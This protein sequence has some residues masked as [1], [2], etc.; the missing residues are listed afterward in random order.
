MLGTVAFNFIMSWT[1]YAQRTDRRRKLAMAAGVAGN[2]A[3]LGYF[4][5]AMFVVSSIETLL[6]TSFGMAAIILPIGISFYIFTQIAFLVD[7]WRER[8]TPFWRDRSRPYG[9]LD[10]LLFVTIFPHLIAGPI[11]H[12]KEMI[13]QFRSPGFGRF[14][15]QSVNT[16][17]AYF[18]LGL[19]KKV[20]IA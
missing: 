16:G 1:I 6:G 18:V 2:L 13:P 12:H 20:L 3:C 15:I 11:I 10:Y 14:D 4:K 5:Y 8:R 9:P 7:I 19:A 17:I